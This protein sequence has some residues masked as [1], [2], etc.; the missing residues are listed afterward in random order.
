MADDVDVLQAR[1][2]LVAFGIA[3]YHEEQMIV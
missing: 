3:E 1:R 2:R